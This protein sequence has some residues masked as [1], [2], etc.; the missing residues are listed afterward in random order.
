MEM[1]EPKM[2]TLVQEHEID[3]ETYQTV[4]L[5]EPPICFMTRQEEHARDRWALPQGQPVITEP[6]EVQLANELRGEWQQFLIFVACRSEKRLNR[7][8]PCEEIINRE[9]DCDCELDCL[10][11][12]GFGLKQG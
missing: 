4:E 2:T 10:A 8:R 3:A 7:E 6:T 12:C 1:T 11:T 9:A 5:G